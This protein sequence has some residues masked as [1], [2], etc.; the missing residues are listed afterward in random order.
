MKTWIIRILLAAL[1]LVLITVLGVSAWMVERFHASKPRQ[2]GEITLSVLDSPAHVV[3]DA[4]GIAHIFGDSDADVMAALG[5]V[6]ASE[7]FFQMDMARRYMRGELS[8]LFG[9]DY[10][11]ADAQTRTYGF[12]RLTEEIV[13]NTSADTRAMMQAY[14]SGVNARLAEGSVAPEY[15]VLRAAPEAWSLEDSA[16]IVVLLAHDLAAGAGAD[17]D[18]ALLDDI[19]SA[20]QLAQFTLNFPDWAPTMLKA[21]DM[22]ARFGEVQTLPLNEPAQPSAQPDNQPGSNAW[23]V[24]GER[25]ETGRPL[26][27]NDPHLG[28]STPAIWYYVRLNLSYGPVIGGTVPGAPFVILGRNAHA[29]WGFTNTG[30]DVIDI[31]E[32]DRSDEE[33]TNRTET[34]QIKGRS[35]PYELTVEETRDGPVLDP[36]WFDLRGF[37]ED[38]I[39]VRRSTVTAPGN[40]VA[41]ATLAIMQAETFDEFVE[42]GRG[43]TAPMQNMHFASVDGTIGY[44]TAGLLPIRD[45]NGEWTGFI[46]FDELPRVRNPEGGFI[47]SGNNLVAGP[48]Y[49]YPLPGSYATYRA[50]R[51]ERELNAR[52]RHTLESFAALQMDVTSEQAL[53]LLPVLLG[54]EPESQLGAEALARLEAWDGALDM[55]APEALIY[56]AWLRVLSG[57]IWNDELDTLASAFNQP[58]RA[59]LEEVL[60]GEASAWCD[61][62]RTDAVESCS[63]TAGLA[64]DAA[65]AETADA[66]GPDMNSWRWGDMHVAD[67]DHPFDSLPLIGS[68]FANR[69]PV[70]GDGATI[71]VAH[72]SYDSGSYDVFHA[73]S[74][75]AIYDLSDLNNSLY[76]FAPGQSGHPLSDHHGDLAPRWAAGEYFEIRDDWAVETAP[77]GSHVLTLTPQ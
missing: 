35:E 14:I 1:A 18:R 65:M 50:P 70:P 45:E 76:M 71:N 24:S 22:R 16:A 10:L 19:L 52:D 9:E 15:A 47:A 4:N 23:V 57:A 17:M 54:S 29:A 64:L 20:E 30:F 33:I 32:R 26:L 72:F 21:E 74:L 73:A 42:A 67:F 7:R 56:S 5:Y 41:D 44:T 11:R 25:S 38:A 34:I 40:R 62:V 49:P 63:I 39:V 46:P 61:D 31:L 53:R 51:I 27:A 69:V 48:D 59:F 3:R 28:L 55:D 68:M 6:H 37:D 75:R 8:A 77:E 12:R 13:A 58:R 43:W 2:S 36:E 60:A 66:F